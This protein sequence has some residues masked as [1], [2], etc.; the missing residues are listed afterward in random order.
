MIGGL[1]KS[2]SSV[3]LIAAAGLIVG[4]VAMP[5]AQA[6]DLGGD[7]C[8][9]L[10]ERVAEL[11]ATTARKGNRRVSL[12]ISG[13]VNRSILFYDD[14]FRS[15]FLSVDNSN[16]TTALVFTGTARIN[17]SLVAGFQIQLSLNTCGRSHQVNQVDD[18]ACGSPVTLNSDGLG[19]AGDALIALDLANW[20][21]AHKDFGTL[22]V[23]RLNTA[24]AGST[25]VDLGGIGVIA[26]SQPVSGFGMLLR[27]GTGR[28]GTYA[29]AAGPN[30]WGSLNCG[31]GQAA[32]A[33][34][35]QADCGF[36]ALSRR[37]GARYDTP[38]FAGFSA[39]VAWGEDDYWDAALRYAGEAAG[40]RVAAAVAYR[41]FRDREADVQVVGPPGGQLKDTDRR[42][43]QGSASI[44]HVAS[45]LFLNG[46][47][48]RY[49]FHGTNQQ[50]ING[51]TGDNRP[52]VTMWY[53]AG[54]ITKN[55]TGLGNTALYA[56]YGQYDNSITGLSTATTLAGLDL[57]P[58]GHFV[59]DSEHQW[60]GLGLVQNIDAAAMELYIGYR[61]YSADVTIQHFG[62]ACCIPGEQIR[63]E[64]IS[65]VQAGSRIRF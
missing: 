48:M 28:L 63:L 4:G 24:S 56:E 29:S 43:L 22:T 20:Y 36:H 38:T 12:T 2:T 46:A 16:A 37:D 5:S 61:R 39:S 50:E 19:G 59:S 65:V 1:W 45:G 15:D 27:S 53:V 44:L 32:G 9:D 57:V 49:E 3:A 14:G 62:V 55:W 10:E 42:A 33:G 23:G 18:D 8:A 31:A 34:V 21:L 7:C 51:L 6:A 54:G 41:S 26:N 13:Q 60:W 11:E 58:A 25:T 17:P 35:Y 47:L 40:F 30:T 52:D 64:D